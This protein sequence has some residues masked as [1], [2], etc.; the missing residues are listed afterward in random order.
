MGYKGDVFNMPNIRGTVYAPGWQPYS[1]GNS[2]IAWSGATFNPIAWPKTVPVINA[3]AN[4]S[5]TP[6]NRASVPVV[7]RYATEPN[8]YMYL[9]GVVGKSKS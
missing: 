1:P 6:R 7:D 2:H 4:N 5:G 3:L 9:A 8:N